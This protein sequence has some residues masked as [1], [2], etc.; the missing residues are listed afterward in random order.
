MVYICVLWN[1]L[2]ADEVGSLR[3]D[4]HKMAKA[5]FSF[6][7]LGSRASVILYK[8]GRRG[9][10]GNHKNCRAPHALYPTPFHSPL[11]PTPA[12]LSGKALTGS[13][14]WRGPAER[15]QSAEHVCVLKLGGAEGRERERGREKGYRKM[16][17]SIIQNNYPALVYYSPV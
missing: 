14:V 16:V 7:E 8:G 2:F 15:V 6:L 17:N 1:L 5:F 4:T 10:V 3:T 12:Q 11:T 13:H 9:S